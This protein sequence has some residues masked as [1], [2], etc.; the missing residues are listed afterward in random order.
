M[1]LENCLNLRCLDR[2]QLHACGAKLNVHLL[3]L[4]IMGGRELP[5]FPILFH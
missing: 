4:V 1:R 2:V 5:D 3:H